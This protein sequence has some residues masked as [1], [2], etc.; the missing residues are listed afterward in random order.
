MKAP[1]GR[2]IIAWGIATGMDVLFIIQALKGRNTYVALSGLELFMR[3]TNPGRCP[4][5]LNYRPFG[6]FSNSFLDS[7]LQTSDSRL[8]I[9]DGNRIELKKRRTVV[10]QMPRKLG[11]SAKRTTCPR[12][13][14]SSI[15]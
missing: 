7:R 8:Y 14:G 13:V 2:N 5:L 9:A 12:P 11:S 15:T 4:G 10:R 3:I 1:K 6:A